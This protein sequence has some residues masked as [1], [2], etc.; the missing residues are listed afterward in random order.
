MLLGLFRQL[1]LLHIFLVPFHAVFRFSG[2]PDGLIDGLPHIALLR[3]DF[4]PRQRIR[5]AVDL[6]HEPIRS[7][8]IGS[9]ERL[10][11]IIG[12]QHRHPH[13]LEIFV[14]LR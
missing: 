1:L 7:T 3:S 11:K 14:F 2:L 9:P 8:H 4:L 12:H 5:I 10:G 13:L 6:D